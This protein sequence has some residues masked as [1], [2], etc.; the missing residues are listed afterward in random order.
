MKV[1]SSTS[2]YYDVKGLQNQSVDLKPNP[3]YNA[4]LINFT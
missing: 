1:L 3:Q 2:L 4:G